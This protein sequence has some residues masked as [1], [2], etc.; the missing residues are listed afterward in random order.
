M[1]VHN[2]D[3]YV[4]IETKCALLEGR[5]NRHHSVSHC[6]P[7]YL[8]ASATASDSSRTSSCVT[9]NGGGYGSVVN[10]G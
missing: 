6:F 7:L 9:G 3:L 5:M 8:A 10:I 4:L 2:I 1:Y